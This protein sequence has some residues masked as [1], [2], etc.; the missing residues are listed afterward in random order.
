MALTVLTRAN[1]VDVASNLKGN[2][3]LVL[4][5]S[6]EPTNAKSRL[7]CLS[8]ELRYLGLGLASLHLLLSW[9]I[10]GRT[11]QLILTALLWLAV[12]HGLLRSQPVSPL[13]RPTPP[14][15]AKKHG[16][17]SKISHQLT[18][19]F[20]VA[21]VGLICLKSTSLFAF[22]SAFVLLLPGLIIFALGL[23]DATFRSLWR[24]QMMGLILTLMLPQGSVAQWV[25]TIMA[26]PIQ[27]L[28]AKSTTFLLHYLSFE[29]F[30]EGIHIYLSAGT[31]RV[32]YECTGVPLLVLLLQITLPIA[33][34]FGLSLR[35][36][37]TTAIVAILTTFCLSSLRIAIM[38]LSVANEQRF[39]YWHGTAGGQV[40]STVAI[41]LFG[42]FCLWQTETQS[43]PAPTEPIKYHSPS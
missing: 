4:D 39:E 14:S 36:S 15:N 28:L 24:W 40:F 8:P 7:A 10:I 34:L 30:R 11:D 37:F 43:S 22:E 16:R 25:E 27:L 31:V 23:L 35:Q 3:P 13:P 29:V 41:A 26:H 19:C 21:L 2:L 12:S 32:D 42:L 5:K 1:V 17:L 9:Q 33:L 20:G 6:M 18:P 38:A